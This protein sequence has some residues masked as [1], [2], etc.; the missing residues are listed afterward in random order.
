MCLGFAAPLASIETYLR[1]R[2]PGSID[3]LNSGA[4]TRHSTLPGQMTELIPGSLNADFSGGAVRVN[5]LG[6]R[7]PEVPEL[8]DNRLFAVGDSVTFGFGVEEKQTFHA[9][10]AQIAGSSG[11]PAFDVVNAGLSGAGLPY[12]YHVIRRQCRALRPN[13]VLVSV[14]LNDLTTYPAAVL[15]DAP[16]PRNAGGAAARPGEAVLTRSYTYVEGFRLFKGLLYKAGVLDLGA[17]PGYH[18]PVL[19]AA[20]VGIEQAW[21]DSFFVLDAILDA[22]QNCG[23]QVVLAVFPLEFQLS[24]EALARY[25]EDIGVDLAETATDFYPQRR[26]ASYA[27]ERNVPFIDFTEAFLGDPPDAL[28]LRDVYLTHDPVHP[29]V[30]GHAR[31]GTL[32]A[33]KLQ[34]WFVGGEPTR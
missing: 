28:F 19:S 11:A 18:F 24:A 10:A 3:S 22:G 2:Y 25:R 27:R 33:E 4:F 6:F 31:A 13:V 20:A 7:G 34:D 26:L 15:E 12:Y 29:S 8:A 9:V 30:L 32:L 5:S 16:L 14:V 17:N 1:L 23:A 21:K